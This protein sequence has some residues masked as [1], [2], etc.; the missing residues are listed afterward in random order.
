MLN[1]KCFNKA[2]KIAQNS[3]LIKNTFLQKNDRLSKIHQCNIFLKREDLQ[4]IR[5]FKIRGAFNKIMN[6]DATATCISVSAG[7][8][9]QGVALTCNKLG[10]KHHIFLPEITP[11]QKVN[12]IRYFGGEHLELHLIGTTFDESLLHAKEFTKSS[13]NTVFVHPFDDKEVI[14][15]QGTIAVEIYDELN[16]KNILPDV[17]IC[18]VGGGGLISGVGM[19]SKQI[20]ENCMIYGVETEKCQFTRFI[21]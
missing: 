4:M 3:N 21:S 8:H 13:K 6:S 7:N 15:G 19:Y 12:R 11:L 5:S 20:N 14:I 9:A 2:F 17:I 1:L 10:R 18:P 16:T